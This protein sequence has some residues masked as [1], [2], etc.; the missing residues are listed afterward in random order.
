LDR[1]GP[2]VRDAAK[3]LEAVKDCHDKAVSIEE[4]M[5]DYRDRAEAVWNDL[6]GQR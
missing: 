5:T 1:A 3:A 2:H 4:T 6:Q